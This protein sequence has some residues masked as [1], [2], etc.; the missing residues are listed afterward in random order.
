MALVAADCLLESVRWPRGALVGLAAAVKLTPAAFVLF[1]LCR[2]DRRAAATAGV[3]F[4]GWSAVGFL[5]APHDSV[6]YWTSVVF[7]TDRP[8]SLLYAANQSIMGVLARADLDPR[9]PAAMGAWLALS[10]VVLALAWRGM[11]RAL[12]ASADAWALSLCAFAALLIS[13]VSWSHHWVWAA[14]A[15]LVLAV[16]SL[17]NRCRFTLAGVAVGLAVFAA[18]PQWWFPSGSNRELHWAAWQQVV[19]SSYVILAVVVL[20]AGAFFDPGRQQIHDFGDADRAQL[21]PPFR[22][23]DPAQVGLAVELREGVPERR[24]GRIGLKR[25]RDVRGEIAALRAFRG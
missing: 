4:A 25:G 3:S 19:G 14:P 20:C 5:L 12:V 13:P 15:L 22:R 6:R 24:G 9:T 18:A 11:R 16:A 21:R 2:G 8:G 7:Q 1:F 17:R 10:A 23:I